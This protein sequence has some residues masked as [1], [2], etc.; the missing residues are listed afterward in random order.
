MT[1]NISPVGGP[2]ASEFFSGGRAPRALLKFQIWC[3]PG[4]GEGEGNFSNEIYQN[5]RGK[6]GQFVSQK[7]RHL[8][9]FC[10][11]R[12]LLGWCEIGSRGVRSQYSPSGWGSSPPKI[13]E[14]FFDFCTKVYSPPFPLPSPP[15]PS[16]TL[17]SPP[18]PSPPLSS[19]STP[20]PLPF[21]FPL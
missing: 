6:S 15:L 10:L 12:Y 11:H 7:L 20:P 4:Y 3:A 17:P 5:V 21:P 13:D 16:P 8:A 9:S 18:L 1:P 19:P 14:I 2:G